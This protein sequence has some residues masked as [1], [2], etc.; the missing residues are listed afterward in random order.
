MVGFDEGADEGVVEGEC[1]GRVGSYEDCAGVA[2]T[3]GGLG[4]VCVFGV[5]PGGADDG[6]WLLRLV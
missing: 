3:V 5:R 4:G 2:A 1:G 6:V